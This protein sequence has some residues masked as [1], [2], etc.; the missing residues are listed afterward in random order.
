MSQPEISADNAEE[1]GCEGRKVVRASCPELFGACVRWGSVLSL[2]RSGRVREGETGCGWPR[3]C[4]VLD[5]RCLMLA[6]AQWFVSS[7]FLNHKR[8]DFRPDRRR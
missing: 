2:G 5:A 7:F 6:G 3:R 1:G 8:T 4:L